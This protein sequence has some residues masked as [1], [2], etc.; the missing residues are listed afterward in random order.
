MN[1]L[2]RVAKARQEYR[3]MSSRN[4]RDGLTGEIV[5][6]PTKEQLDKS[7]KYRFAKH[8]TQKKYAKASRKLVEEVKCDC[9]NTIRNFNKKMQVKCFS[10]NH[11]HEKID[12]TWTK[13]EKVDRNTPTIGDLLK[14][15][16][17]VSFMR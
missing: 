10:C 8:S 11:Y 7:I 3:E 1:E 17:K 5:T 6:L 16:K 13:Q 15:G 2:E 14:S 12:G 4:W 9:G